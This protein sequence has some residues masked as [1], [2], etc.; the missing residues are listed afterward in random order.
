MGGRG[1]EGGTATHKE[2][3]EKKIDKFEG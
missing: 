3:K 1:E 2:I